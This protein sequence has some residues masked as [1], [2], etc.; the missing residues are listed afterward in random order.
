MNATTVHVLNCAKNRRFAAL[1]KSLAY[2]GSKKPHQSWRNNSAE[3]R[4][5][6]LTTRATIFDADFAA[7]AGGA[8]LVFSHR[9]DQN[10]AAHFEEPFLSGKAFHWQVIV[11]ARLQQAKIDQRICKSKLFPRRSGI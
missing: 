9:V 6:L 4:C 8:V 2:K 3:A 7:S 11:F 10:Q 1:S 5:H